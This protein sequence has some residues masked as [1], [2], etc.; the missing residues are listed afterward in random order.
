MDLPQISLGDLGSKFQIQG[1]PS[2]PQIQVSGRFNMNSALAGPTAG[3]NQYQVR[4][5]FS[6]N[7]GRHSLRLGGEAV[8]EKMIHDA[9]LTNYG[10]FRFTTTNPIGT[11][12]AVADWLLGLPATMAQDAPTTKI[13]NSWYYGLFVQD[14]FRIH[15]SLT[16]NLGARWDI[17]P[18]ITDPHDR[19]DTFVP[20]KQSVIVKS[21]PAGLLF[22]G[23]PGVGRGIISTDWNNVSPRVGLAWD[24]F[25]DRKTAI[26]AAAG[27]FYGSMSGNEWNASSDNQP[28]AIRQTFTASAARRH[29]LGVFDFRPVPHAAGRRVAVPVQLLSDGA[30]LRARPR[31]WW[32]SIWITSRRTAT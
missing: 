9:L 13:D 30:A 23:D 1:T 10:D 21:A 25:G 11:K 14:D 3:S 7:H 31:R 24:P 32:R 4:D 29:R 20:G 6:I 12:N 16:L 2:L 15:P 22:P 17:Q 27:I 18:P 28:F 19:F 26:R 8:L 5:L